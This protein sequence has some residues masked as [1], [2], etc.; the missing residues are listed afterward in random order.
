[1]LILQTSHPGNWEHPVDMAIQRLLFF[2][3]VHSVY[4]ESVRAFNL[5]YVEPFLLTSVTNIALTMR[6]F[7]FIDFFVYVLLS[8]MQYLNLLFALLPLIRVPVFACT[9]LYENMLIS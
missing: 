1:M 7:S 2:N 4:M 5:F 3:Q 8:L 6:S 9:R